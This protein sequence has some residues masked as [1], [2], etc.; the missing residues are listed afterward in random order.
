MAS[1]FPG[2]MRPNDR[3]CRGVRIVLQ[4]ISRQWHGHPLDKLGTGSG[5]VHGLHRQASLLGEAHATVGIVIW[6]R[7]ACYILFCRPSATMR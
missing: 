3:L 5:R 4:R 6:N 1:D 2:P 7:R